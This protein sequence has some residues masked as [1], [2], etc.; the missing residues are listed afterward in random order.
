MTKIISITNRKGGVGKST[1]AVLLAGCLAKDRKVLILDCDEQRSIE[2]LA[3]LERNMY[4]GDPLFDVEGIALQFVYDFLK[5]KG[6]QYDVIFLDVPRFTGSDSATMQ[7]LGCCDAVLIP[8]L[9]STLEVLSIIDFINALQTL[10]DYKEKNN[11]GFNFFGVMNRVTRRSEN[12][13]TKQILES[14][15]LPMFDSSLSDVKLFTN[16]SV[17]NCILDTKE[18]KRRFTDFYNEFKSKIID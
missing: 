3:A 17:Y 1:L 10:S 6:D 18:G 5:L 14:R 7:T 13:E 15:G 16:P 9:G 11:I 2:S 8:C 12:N 4:E